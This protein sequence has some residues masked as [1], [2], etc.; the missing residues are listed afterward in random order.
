MSHYWLTWTR[1]MGRWRRARGKASRKRTLRAPAARKATQLHATRSRV[2]EGRGR[3]ACGQG[4]SCGTLME[5]SS[6]RPWRTSMP[7]A[8]PEPSSVPVGTT[9]WPA[10]AA[11]R[12]A[13]GSAVTS[14][15]RGKA[16]SPWP[17]PGQAGQVGPQVRPFLEHFGHLLPLLR[18]TLLAGG[19]GPEAGTGRAASSLAAACHELLAAEGVR[20]HPRATPSASGQ[21]SPTGNSASVV[22][23]CTS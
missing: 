1:L 10:R 7:S 14:A 11:C 17:W 19:A 2:D 23:R 4:H 15:M 13:T 12:G 21:F 6:S 16:A 18:P 3:S 20:C 8:A 22:P 5:T 9:P